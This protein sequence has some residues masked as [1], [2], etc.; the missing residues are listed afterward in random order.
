MNKL[1]DKVAVVYGNGAVGAAIARAFTD[2]GAKVFL[3]GLTL[4]KLKAIADEILFDGGSIEIAQL[5]ALDEKAVE[6]HMSDVIKKAGKVD[7]SFNAI[8]IYSKD[9]QHIPLTELSVD[10]FFLPVSTYVKSHF[11]T[12]RAAARRM[13]KQGSGV[14]VMHTA[15]PGRISA[16]FAGGRAPAW[17]AM[18]SICR[19]FSVECGEYGVRTVCLFSTAIPETP[20]IEEAFNELYEAS[21]KAS[22]ITLE[23]FYTAIESHTHRKQLTTLKEVTDAAVFVTS[24]EGTAITGTILNL[25]AGMVV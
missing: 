25:T 16:P 23:Q 11:I 19:S 5:D 7:I 15:S 8:G 1:K 4:A 18:E 12:A 2:E 10:S 13:I 20:V 17:A 22:G 3:T 6:K 24:N 9:V 14:I 21:A